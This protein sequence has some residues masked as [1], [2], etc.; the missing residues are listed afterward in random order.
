VRVSEALARFT[1]E[2]YR[3]YTGYLASGFA[4]PYEPAALRAQTYATRLAYQQAI[5][6]YIYAWKQLVAALGLPQLPLTEVAGRVDRLIPYYDYDAVLAHILAH[7]TDVQTARNNVQKAQYN[8][9]LSQITPYPD[10]DLYGAVWK[11]STIVPYAIFY[12]VQ[13]GVPIPIWDQ[14]KGN[15]KSAQ[16]ALIRAVE[17]ARRVEF[18][19]TNNLATNYLNYKNNLDA[20][21]FYRRHILPDQVRNYRGVFEHR[22]IDPTASPTELVG[23]QAALSSSLTSYLGILSQLWTSVVGVADLMQ[24]DDLFQLAKP[25]ELPEL[26]ALDNLPH[27]NSPSGEPTLPA[28][29]RLK[30]LPDKEPQMNTAEPR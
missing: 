15:I 20:L 25:R 24:T 26:P 17:E 3:L 18:A 14:N 12:S 7:H 27:L 10:M 11:E 29:N 1:D 28:P 4:A 9:K 21:E 5:T 16:A 30:P 2:I 19:L 23:A 6:G 13:V 8:L 22:Q